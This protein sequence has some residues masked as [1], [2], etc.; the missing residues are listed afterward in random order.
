[1]VTFLFLIVAFSF[2]KKKKQPIRKQTILPAESK[3]T[4]SICK[5]VN[6]EFTT[7]ENEENKTHYKRL[8]N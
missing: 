4:D 1:V 2:F 5:N 3:P 8:Q 7:I 6:K